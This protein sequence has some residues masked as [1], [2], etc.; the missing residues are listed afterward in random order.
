MPGAG[1]GDDA[2]AVS[3]DG[4]I[5]AAYTSAYRTGATIDVW[6]R[7][8]GR[9]LGG[10]TFDPGGSTLDVAAR[11]DAALAV[12]AGTGLTLWDARTNK[13]QRRVDLPGTAIDDVVFGADG[14][15]LAGLLRPTRPLL[16]NVDRGAEVTTLPISANRIRISPD[17]R[18]AAASDGAHT[19]LVETRSGKRV[20]EVVT[21]SDPVFSSDG[22]VL[23]ATTS[24][25]AVHV[26]R[27]DN[28]KTIGIVELRPGF[29]VDAVAPSGDGMLLAVAGGTFGGEP[30]GAGRTNDLQLWEVQRNALLGSQNLAT[31]LR[32]TRSLDVR[33]LS[34]S[35]QLVTT[36]FGGV[37]VWDVDAD[38]WA[39]RACALVNRALTRAEWSV[40]VGAAASYD[41]A[42]TGH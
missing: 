11:D 20:G 10:G 22:R 27:A 34:E 28:A 15:A 7:R 35:G 4:N 8:S 12:W 9:R 29:Q 19:W 30:L 39:A 23:A 16:W 17:G 3:P 37:V 31:G 21:G 40:L 42:C 25:G 2:V 5:I 32:A 13:T 6:D 33:F 14:A 26:K 38:R 24:A 41:P 18:R 36:G 1:S